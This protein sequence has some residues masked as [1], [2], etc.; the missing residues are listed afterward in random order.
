[1][2]NKYLFI[3]IIIYLKIE[4]RMQQYKNKFFVGQSC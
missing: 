1:M 2:N 4:N 3:I